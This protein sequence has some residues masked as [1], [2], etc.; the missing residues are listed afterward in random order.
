[1]SEVYN[2]DITQEVSR[3]FNEILLNVSTN[4]E[5]SIV[6]KASDTLV[7]IT[8]EHTET[9]VKFHLEILEN[10]VQMLTDEHWKMMEFEKNYIISVLQYLTEENDIIPD[11]IPSVGLLDDCIMIEIVE[12]KLRNKIKAYNAFKSA[13]KV[14][15]QDENFSTRDWADIKKKEL[16]SRIRNRRLRNSTNR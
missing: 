9:Y 3:H 14:Y 12:E 4:D 13:A 2:L 6:A 15:S 8:D 16:F 10:M 1:M 11:N 7:K 5:A